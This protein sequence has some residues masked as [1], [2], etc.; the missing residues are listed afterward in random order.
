MEEIVRLEQ[1]RVGSSSARAREGEAPRHGRRAKAAC[2]FSVAL[3]TASFGC[4]PD[5]DIK[6]SLHLESV[7]T[8]WV[9]GGRVAAGNKLVPAVSF[10]VKNASNETLAPVQVNAIFRR[11]GH[12]E[13]WSNGMV[14]AADSR[15]LAPAAASDRLTIA[16]TLG[17]TGTDSQWDM[18][19]NSQFVDA[20]VDLFARYG[21]R[22]WVPVG[23]YP[24]SRII[25][26]R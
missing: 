8:G 26:E 2:Y 9:D 5:V 1:T 13:E 11:V 3:L 15:G 10:K 24:I 12:E 14:T 22:Q 19:Q 6:S 25:V 21:S 17:Y 16:G 7:V 4:G 18:L 20:R 23:Q